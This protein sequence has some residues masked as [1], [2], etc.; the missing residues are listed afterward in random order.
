MTQVVLID[1]HALVRAGIR[2]LLQKSPGIKVVGE[3]GSGEEGVRLV[4][5]LHPDVVL[6][7]FKLPDITGLEV[8]ARLLRI[9]PQIKIIMLS[10]A[11]NDLFPLRSLEAGARGYLTK[12]A[13]KEELVRSIHAVNSGQKVISPLI[14]SRLALAKIDDKIPTSY[15]SLGNKEFEVMMMTIRGVPIKEIADRLHINH[16][17]IHSYR[18]RIFEKLQVNNDVDLTLLAIREGLITAEEAEG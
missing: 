15:A 12:N 2:Q 3:A 5:D 18:C 9:D 4:R 10:S 6:L 8:T 14:A 1:D 7:D 17:T 13:S 16:K 11:I